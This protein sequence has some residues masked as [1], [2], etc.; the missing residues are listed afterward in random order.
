MQIAFYFAMITLGRTEIT[1]TFFSQNE[2]SQGWWKDICPTITPS[3][4][5]KKKN[6]FRIHIKESDPSLSLPATRKVS[7]EPLVTRASIFLRVKWG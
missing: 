6:S 1:I 4:A 2:M 5:R 7:G 3:L